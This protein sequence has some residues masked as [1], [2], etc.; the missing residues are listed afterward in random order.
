MARRGGT[1]QG[2]NGQYHRP[3]TIKYLSPVLATP[4]PPEDG[5]LPSP[6]SHFIYDDSGNSQTSFGDLFTAVLGSKLSKQSLRYPRLSPADSPLQIADT[7]GGL[8]PPDAPKPVARKRR[9]PSYLEPSVYEYRASDEREQLLDTRCI[10]LIRK[11]RVFSEFRDITLRFPP[12]RTMD[13]VGE[14]SRVSKNALDT[15]RQVE[16]PAGCDGILRPA[17]GIRTYIIKALHLR[18]PRLPQATS[19][20]NLLLSPSSSFWPEDG[21]SSPLYQEGLV[22]GNEETSDALEKREIR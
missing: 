2:F 11:L 10:R 4:G 6:V 5:V 1:R 15:G 22:I 7:V 21:D 12:E 18:E 13:C 3:T 16:K 9:L 8:S 19:Q 14:N 17:M 20:P